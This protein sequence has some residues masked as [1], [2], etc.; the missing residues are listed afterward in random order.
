MTDDGVHEHSLRSG[1]VAY[2]RQCLDLCRRFHTYTRVARGDGTSAWELAPGIVDR[3]LPAAL[4]TLD[5]EAG[6]MWSYLPD[7]VTD[8][9][10]NAYDGVPTGPNPGP[11]WSFVAGRWYRDG[12]HDPDGAEATRRR[13]A[14]I[15]PAEARMIALVCGFLATAADACCIAD[16]LRE[17]TGRALTEGEWT[18]VPRSFTVAHPATTDVHSCL[19]REDS[20]DRNVR[21]MLRS[22]M[23]W[24]C[25][26]LTRMPQGKVRI[27]PRAAVDEATLVML[28]MNTETIIT[29][30]YDET[31][32][33]V[34]GRRP[35]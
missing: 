20:D 13:Q 24:S 28:A 4:L 3:T 34:W 19:D 18:R 14:E 35:G 33:L 17:A 7:G 2:L 21:E 23:H 16:E 15:R 32:W 27:A 26:A 8:D 5:L 29:R 25:I 6:R 30:A 22:G 31:G 10:A 11:G 12:V 9:E 1:A